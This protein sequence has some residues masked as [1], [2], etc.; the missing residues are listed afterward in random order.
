MI[1]DVRLTPLRVIGDAHGSVMHMLRQTDP[2]FAG[3]GEVYFSTLRIAAKKNWRQHSRATSQLAVPHG[4]V[5]FVLCDQRRESAT[6]GMVSELEIGEDN[7][8]LLTIPP[9]VWFAFQN[10]GSDD[11]LIANCSNITHDPTEVERRDFET[12]LIPYVWRD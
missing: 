4:R 8:Q 12:P 6:T 5:R 10:I 9:L 11:A 1:Q 3:F 2:H 7:Y